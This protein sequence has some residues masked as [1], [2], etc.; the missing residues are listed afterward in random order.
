MAMDSV[1]RKCSY[2]TILV[3]LL[4]D[5]TAYVNRS[6]SYGSTSTVCDMSGCAIDSDG[7][8]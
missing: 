2:N 8:S 7:D 3:C 6:V 4:W 5:K 1:Q